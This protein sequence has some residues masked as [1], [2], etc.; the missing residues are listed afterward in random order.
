M[1]SPSIEMETS[2]IFVVAD[3][4]F[5][6]RPPDFSKLYRLKLGDTLSSEVKRFHTASEFPFYV[7]NKDMSSMFLSRFY[8]NI[9]TPMIITAKFIGRF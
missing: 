3:G 5:L 9:P 7:R 4:V 1:A 8:R 6:F 2:W